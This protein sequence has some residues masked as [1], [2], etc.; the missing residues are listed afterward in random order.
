[1]ILCIQTVL[2]YRKEKLSQSFPGENEMF[3]TGEQSVSRCGTLCFKVR[4]DSKDIKKNS[5]RLYGALVTLVSIQ[6]KT[7]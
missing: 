4:N 1:M 6:I 3:L 2:I 5:K 7:Y